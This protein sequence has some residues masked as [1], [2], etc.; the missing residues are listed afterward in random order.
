M[1]LNSLQAIHMKIDVGKVFMLGL[2][3]FV[4]LNHYCESLLFE[5]FNR[6][7]WCVKSWNIKLMPLLGLSFHSFVSLTLLA[8]DTLLN[9]PIASELKLIEDWEFVFLFQDWQERLWIKLQHRMQE[10]NLT[11]ALNLGGRVQER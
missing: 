11:V 8:R 9:E 3:F 5:N 2:I 1:S 7:D 6:I 4:K 10:F